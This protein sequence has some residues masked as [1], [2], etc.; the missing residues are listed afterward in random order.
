MGSF[1]SRVI[2]ATVPLAKRR[3]KNP[4]TL[5]ASVPTNV[6]QIMGP[7]RAFFLRTPIDLDLRREAGRYAIEYAPLNLSVYGKTEEAAYSAFAEAFEVVWEEIVE[8][9][10]CSLT[11]DARDLKAAFVTLSENV[12]EHAARAKSALR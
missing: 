10:N 5:T 7:N 12:Q 8:S 6:I 2:P 3:V 11:E 1:R 9:P 4:A